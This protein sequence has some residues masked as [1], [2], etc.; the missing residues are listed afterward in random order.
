MRTRSFCKL[1]EVLRHRN[2]PGDND[3]VVDEAGLADASGEEDEG[4]P[5]DGVEFLEGLFV[6]DGDV[7]EVDGGRCTPIALRDA[8]PSF[9]EG[10]RGSSG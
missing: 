5:V 8:P 9:C 3:G 2:A 7:V 10:L 4:G 1:A 6:G